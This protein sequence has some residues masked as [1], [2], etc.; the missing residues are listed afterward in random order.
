MKK[1]GETVIV[2]HK[3]VAFLKLAGDVEKG[4]GHLTK[5]KQGELGAVMVSAANCRR[6][7]MR[8]LDNQ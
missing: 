7:L 5:A 8:I 2:K 1:C 3:H 4:G 6:D